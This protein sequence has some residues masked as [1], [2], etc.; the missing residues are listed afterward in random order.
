MTRETDT[1]ATF[2]VPA[3]WKLSENYKKRMKIS[4][5][6]IIFQIYFFKKNINVTR[7]FRGPWLRAEAR[8]RLWA[9]ARV[10]LAFFPSPFTQVPHL[11]KAARS[12]QARPVQD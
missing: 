7:A 4:L 3:E 12:W 1:V 2:E 5:E 11:L 8:V 6:K 10:R 9:Y